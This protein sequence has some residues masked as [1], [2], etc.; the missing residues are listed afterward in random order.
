MPDT[1]ALAKYYETLTNAELLNLK[2][3]GGFTEE[4]ECVLAQELRRRKLDAS[5]LKR[6]EVQRERIR[7]REETTEKGTRG[8]GPGLLFFGGRYPSE[9]DRKAN[10]QVRTKWFAL[11]GIPLVPVASYR[12]HFGNDARGWSSGN[13]KQRVIDRVPLDWTQVLLT[14]LKT[15]AFLALVVLLGAGIIWYHNHRAF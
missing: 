10:I 7:L 4:A 5:D 8:W 15:A 14:W 11:G 12:F 1:I 3:E 6:N 9:E 2:R 13:G